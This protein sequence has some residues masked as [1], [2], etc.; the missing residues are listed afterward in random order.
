MKSSNAYVGLL[1]S[2]KSN[3]SFLNNYNHQNST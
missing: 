1:K 3:N 2:K